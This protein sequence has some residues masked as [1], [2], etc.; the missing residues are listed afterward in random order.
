[1]VAYDLEL[2]TGSSIY[3]GAL[4]AAWEDQPFSVGDEDYQDLVLQFTPVPEPASVVLLGLGLAGMAGRY[5]RKRR[6][7]A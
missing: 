6:S 2:L 7:V 1:M 3:S 5:A 4:L